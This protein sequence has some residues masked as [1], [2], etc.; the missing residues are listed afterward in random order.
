MK[1]KELFSPIRAL[2][3]SSMALSLVGCQTILPPAVTDGDPIS[4]SA[5]GER[6]GPIYVEPKKELFI[7]DLSVVEDPKRTTGYGPWTFGTLMARMANGK[8]PSKF[9]LDWLKTW[10]TDQYVNGDVVKARKLGIDHVIDIWPKLPN[11]KLDLTK[12]PFRLQAIV[13]RLDLRT[14]GNAGE[15]RFVFSFVDPTP[16]NVTNVPGS[17]PSDRTAF[18]VIFEYGVTDGMITGDYHRDYSKSD[19][20]ERMRAVSDWTSRWH[21]LA[22]TPY[23][24]AYNTALQKITDVFT[25]ENANPTKPR[26][27]ALNQL[28]TNEIQLALIGAFGPGG[29][30]NPSNPP[31]WEMREFHAETSGLNP[32]PVALTPKVSLNNTTTLGDYINENEAAILKDAHVLPT[33]MLAGAAPVPGAIGDLPIL[34]NA[35]N[36]AHPDDA[37]FK[38]ALNTCSGC[39]LAEAGLDKPTPIPFVAFLQVQPRFAGQEAV[40]STFMTGK[41][42]KDPITG[43]VRNLNDLQRRAE[44]MKTVLGFGMGKYPIVTYDMEAPYPKRVH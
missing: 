42:V 29:S 2:I 16:G 25:K 43:K 1:G 21:K 32:V 34:W 37:R 30:F 23:G 3:M 4:T 9:V 15:N 40:L 7:T 13:N 28:R 38:F 17:P 6:S 41:D 11:G 33:P 35:P 19:P 5:R 27:S 22:S 31:A 10:Q 24:P 14:P 39:H 12:A 36:I 8:D 20:K 18:T 26:G 44:D